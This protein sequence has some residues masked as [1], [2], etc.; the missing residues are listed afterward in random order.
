MKKAK[1]AK[2]E[3]DKYTWIDLMVIVRVWLRNN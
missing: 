2:L 3:E 1:Q